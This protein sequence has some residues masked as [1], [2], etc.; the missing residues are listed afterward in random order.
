MV[1]QLGLL[2]R[3][4]TDLRLIV[5]LNL[6]SFIVCLYECIARNHLQLVTLIELVDGHV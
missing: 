6:P 5:Q 1:F 4:T 2:D 3:S